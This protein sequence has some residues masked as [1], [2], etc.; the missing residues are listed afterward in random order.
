MDHRQLAVQVLQGTH[1][2]HRDRKERKDGADITV[3][4]INSDKALQP[5]PPHTP[6]CV[7]GISVILGILT[8]LL[9]LLSLPSLTGL[10]DDS[11]TSQATLPEGITMAHWAP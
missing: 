5:T 4:G 8:G 6:A 2:L 3:D 11:Y 7:P 10:A 9:P 1:D